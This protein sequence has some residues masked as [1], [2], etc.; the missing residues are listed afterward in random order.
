MEKCGFCQ[1]QAE[2]RVELD[3]HL[4]NFHS[5]HTRTFVCLCGEV[6]EREEQ[7]TFHR[8]HRCSELV[9]TPPAVNSSDSEKKKKEKKEKS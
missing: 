8:Y 6:F 1:H 9:V 2:S 7:L 4:L 3:N 5:P